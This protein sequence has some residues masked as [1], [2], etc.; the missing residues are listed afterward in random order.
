MMERFAAI[1]GL[2]L[3]CAMPCVANAS[4]APAAQGS[5][6]VSGHISVATDGSVIS[7]KLDNP[8]QL[9]HGIVSLL[10]KA[11]PHWRF[12]PVLRDN[13][14]VAARASMRIRVVARPVAEKKYAI[15]IGSAWFGDGTADKNSPTM[16]VTYKSRTNPHYPTRALRQH[17]SGTAIVVARINKQGKVDKID[18]ERVNLRTSGDEQRMKRWRKMLAD[19]SI[20]AIRNW[21]FRIPSEGPEADKDH[22]VVRI[23]ISYELNDSSRGP[24]DTYGKWVA[25]IPGPHKEIPW[26][27]KDERMKGSV[28]A[29]PSHGL[30]MADSSSLHLISDPN[31]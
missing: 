12:E 4:K 30:F 15:S 27:D 19:A 14:T 2:L 5:M 3:I 18:A 7:Y 24:A 29:L 8:G 6:V 16:S 1:L 31:S 10:H 28:D 26:L 9:P 17:I 11:I 23:P 20:G 13:K 22:W 25:Y 21:T